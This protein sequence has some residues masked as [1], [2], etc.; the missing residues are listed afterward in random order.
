MIG[1][2]ISVLMTFGCGIYLGW[3]LGYRACQRDF[4][5]TIWPDKWPRARL[6]ESERAKP[7][8]RQHR[9]PSE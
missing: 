6:P 7:D 3:A 2:L 4:M 5:R 1:A 9:E 8:R